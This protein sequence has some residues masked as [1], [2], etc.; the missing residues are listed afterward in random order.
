MIRLKFITLIAGTGHTD[1]EAV[2]RCEGIWP[3]S[4]DQSTKVLSSRP[5]FSV[6]EFADELNTIF[7]VGSTRSK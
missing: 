4:E 6:P 2:V 3:N 5:V 7:P 1:G